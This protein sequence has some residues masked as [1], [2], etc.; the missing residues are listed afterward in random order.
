MVAE[1]EEAFLELDDSQGSGLEDLKHE[2]ESQKLKETFKCGDRT[3]ALE[4][5]EAEIFKKRIKDRELKL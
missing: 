1:L 5:E 4:K 3:Y 2:V